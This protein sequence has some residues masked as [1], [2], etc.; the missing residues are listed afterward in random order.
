MAAATSTHNVAIAI[1]SK[2]P[3]LYPAARIAEPDRR[4]V[5]AYCDGG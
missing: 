5:D 1:R 4:T 3:Q 2:S